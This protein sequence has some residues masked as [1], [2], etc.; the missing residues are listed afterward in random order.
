[1]Q[2]VDEGNFIPRI[3]GKIGQIS[4]EGK[5][6]HDKWI[7]TVWLTTIG[8]GDGEEIGTFGLFDTQAE[9]KRELESAVRTMSDE[10]EK[11]MTGKVSGKYIDMK[12]NT[13]R[14]WD[15]GEVH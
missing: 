14:H 2:K 5:P 8:G 13:L 3:R 15:K 4:S 9:A 11:H 7:F 12:T 6:D 10:I 1:M